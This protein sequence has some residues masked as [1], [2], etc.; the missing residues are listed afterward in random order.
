VFTR[1]H[2]VIGKQVAFDAQIPP[3]P[4]LRTHTEFAF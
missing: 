1:L 3:L 4:G 2:G